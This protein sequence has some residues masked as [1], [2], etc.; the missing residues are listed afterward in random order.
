MTKIAMDAWYEQLIVRAAT[1]DE[2][3]CDGFAAL[4][5]RQDDADRV[6]RRLAAWCRACASGDTSLFARRLQRDGWTVDRVV[7]KFAAVRRDPRAR[8]PLWI[9]DAIWIEPA[10]TRPCE[11]RV[12]ALD[13]ARPCPFEHL[14]APLIEQAQARLW[15]GMD[16]RAFDNLAES[17]RADLR[18]GLLVDLT[19]LCAPLLYER[20]VKVTR[21]GATRACSAQRDSSS[22]QYQRFIVDMRSSGLR[23]L[24]DEKPVLLRLIATI[25]RQ[26]LDRSRDF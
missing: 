6:A 24:F 19:D 11:S 8:L 25:T 4:P 10:F 23:R 20:F 22:P 7:E 18:H 13:P 9:E 2:L 1:I 14:F 5:G 21:R 3:L 17:A 26:W 15:A 12:A 16:Q